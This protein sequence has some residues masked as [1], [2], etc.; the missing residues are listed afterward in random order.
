VTAEAIDDAADPRLDDFRRLQERTARRS[1]GP[2]VAEGRLVVERLLGSRFPVRALLATPAAL[3]ALAGPLAGRGGPAFPIWVARARVIGAVVGFE[4]HRGCLALGERR[5]E[6]P[7]DLVEGPGPRALLALDGLADPDNVGAVFRNA[8]AFGVSG[9]LLSAAAADPLYRKAI[10]TSAAAT[11]HVPFARMPDWREGMLRLRAAGY[12]VVGLTPEAGA[13]DVG[14]L[15]P[16]P[17]R[18]AVVLGSEGQGLGPRTRDLVDRLVRIPMAP[19]ADSL[20]VATACG[21]AL[22]RLLGPR[23]AGR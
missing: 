14:M 9:V 1:R 2:F 3:G 23:L 16:P 10:R 20:N 6:A 4:F 7:A 8:R 18:L 15:P 19:G 22:H 13:D 5:E 17:G 12:L 21:I 11:L